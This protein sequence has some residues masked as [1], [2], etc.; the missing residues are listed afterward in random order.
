MWWTILEQ[1]TITRLVVDKFFR[2]VPFAKIFFSKRL[3]SNEVVHLVE[4]EQ[5]I[6][7]VDRLVADADSGHVVLKVIR[8]AFDKNIGRVKQISVDVA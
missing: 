7:V 1:E 2:P 4:G 6:A 8:A 3:A 5:I